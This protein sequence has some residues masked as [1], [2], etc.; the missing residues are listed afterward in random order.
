M[1]SRKD[2]SPPLYKLVVRALQ[3][4]IVSGIYPVGTQLPSEAALR[5]RFGIS[6]H[7]VREALRSLRDAGLVESHQGLGTVVLSPGIDQTYVHQIDSISDLFD[8][9]VETRYGPVNGK[10]VR[11]PAGL[12]K[13]IG[14]SEDQTWIRIDALRFQSGEPS[15]LC[16]TE[17]YVASRFAG[18]GRLMSRHNGSVYR[19]IETI[20]GETIEEV[21]Q[22]V[23]GFKARKD[24]NEAIN[25]QDGDA[26]IVIERVF[27]ISSDNEVAIVSLNRY[28]ADRFSLSLVLKKQ[29]A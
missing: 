19:L 16:Q 3:S 8:V 21:K 12:S 23:R 10:L 4:E 2:G 24:E 25:L 5:E 18:V 15:P 22:E 9:N 14:V 13:K 20:Y 7:T 26:G 17:I 6:R 29:R 27:R 1:S 11:L 28:P